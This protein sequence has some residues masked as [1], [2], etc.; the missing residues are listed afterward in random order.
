MSLFGEYPCADMPIAPSYVSF[1][2]GSFC[3]PLSL[4][5]IT[6]NVLVVLAILLDPNNNLRSPFNY[7]VVNLAVADLIVGIVVEP[8]SLVYLY[9]EGISGAYPASLD[10]VF[11]PYFVSSTASV[12]SLAALTFDRYIAITSPLKYRLKLSSKRAAF[13]AAGIWAF[14]LTFP[15]IYFKT[16]Y[17]TYAFVF[18]HTAIVFTF[19][20]M[21]YTHAKIFR[22][23]RNQVQQWDN[24]SEAGETNF[25]R[26]Q[27]A[28]WE[29]KVT[30]TFVILL[31]FFLACYLPS[32]VC[33]YITNLCST[34]SCVSVHWA[35]D[36]HF[37]LVMANSSV[38]PFVYAWRFENFRRACVK[39]LAACCR[40]LRQR[41]Y[42][43]R[44]QV[45]PE[46]SAT[47]STPSPA[48]EESVL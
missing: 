6:G 35:R 39:I 8:L 33:I 41:S 28:R 24:P 29:Q 3:V 10:Y 34:C 22:V 47:G 30:K 25:A 43:P 4:V 5:T 12:L 23:F 44:G 27:A 31:A 11:V 40:R 45:Q 38:N 18:A 13:V 7:F 16:G 17:L 20:V 21:I 9:S 42:R 26:R 2:T 46:V 36:I 1:T 37:V 15:L 19:A 32:C 48:S 14:S